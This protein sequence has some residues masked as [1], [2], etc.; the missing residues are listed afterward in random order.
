MRADWSGLLL[1]T[2]Q[3]VRIPQY[4]HEETCIV[5]SNSCNKTLFCSAISEIASHGRRKCNAWGS[6]ASHGRRLEKNNN[7]KKY[8]KLLIS[9]HKLCSVP[10]VTLKGCASRP[11]GDDVALNSRGSPQSLPLTQPGVQTGSCRLH[12]HTLGEKNPLLSSLRCQGISADELAC[13]KPHSQRRLQCLALFAFWRQS[14]AKVKVGQEGRSPASQLV[15]RRQSNLCSRPLTRAT[16]PRWSDK[17]SATSSKW[18]HV[19]SVFFF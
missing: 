19:L 12:T 8:I 15:G 16:R 10:T 18:L 3:G 14:R 11:S 6:S 17:D 4:R 1:I 9:L 7:K 13:Q 2:H 5:F